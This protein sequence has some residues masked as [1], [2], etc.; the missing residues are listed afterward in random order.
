MSDKTVKLM[1]GKR[2]VAAYSRYPFEECMKKEGTIFKKLKWSD[3]TEIPDYQ[4]FYNEADKTYWCVRVGEIEIPWGFGADVNGEYWANGLILVSRQNVGKEP[5]DGRG[6]PF[7]TEGEVTYLY[8]CEL[9]DN[10]FKGFS[11][12]MRERFLNAIK[13]MAKDLPQAEF[14]KAFSA[15]ALKKDKEVEEI[16]SLHKLTLTKVILHGIGE[17]KQE[18]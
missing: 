5:F 7:T 14:E 11:I 18:N 17:Q 10:G 6:L 3:E 13:R 1:N 15:E 8:E 2:F 12:Y 4:C 16:L 9:T